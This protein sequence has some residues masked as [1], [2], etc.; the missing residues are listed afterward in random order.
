MT[1]H[2]PEGTKVSSE[3]SFDDL[4]ELAEKS[5]EKKH[6]SLNDTLAAILLSLSAIA[7]AWCSY[8]SSIW[9]GISSRYA[10]EAGQYEVVATEHSIEDSQKRMADA[11]IVTR[12]MEYLSSGRQEYAQFMLRTADANLR[13]AI[14]DWLKLD[15]VNNSSALQSPMLMQSYKRPYLDSANIFRDLSSEKNAG[16]READDVSDRYLLLSV[17]LAVALFFAGM[18]GTFRHRRLQLVSILISTIIFAS[19]LIG[20]AR[21]P[22]GS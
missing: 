20:I 8:Q 22:V 19:V 2:I 5:H 18:S 6:G 15:P 14:D 3:K 1:K 9:D 10:N 16:A 11:G 7:S 17:A 12:Y 21:Q 13:T 4:K